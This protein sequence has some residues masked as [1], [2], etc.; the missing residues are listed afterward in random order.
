MKEKRVSPLQLSLKTGYS[1]T[2]I[3]GLSQGLSSPSI[4]KA[5]DIAQTLGVTDK[6]IW[7]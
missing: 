5:R 7:P 3:Y 1:R 2:S 4:F 6:E